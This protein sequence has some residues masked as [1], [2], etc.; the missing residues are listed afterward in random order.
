[1]SEKNTAMRLTRETVLRGALALLNEIGIDALSTRRLAQHLGVQSPTLYWHFKNKAELLKAMAET[2]MLDHREEVP[3]DM[4]WQDWVVTNAGNFRRALLAYRDGARLHAG[5][6]PQEPQF[7][8]IE[9]KV[10]LLCRAGLTPERA[11]NVLFAVGRFVVGWVLEEQQMQPD[12]TLN[13][14][15]RQRYPLLCQGWEILQ[16]KG[17]DALFE[18]SVR[19]LVDGAE[20]GQ[21]IDN[22]HGR[23]S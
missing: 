4:P 18:A 22:N 20:A 19:L 9:A 12:D 15:D 6:R 23:Q 3:A 13:D 1:M 8:I 14:A 17:A 16:E 21:A 7:A 5:T 10:A 11:V 2:I